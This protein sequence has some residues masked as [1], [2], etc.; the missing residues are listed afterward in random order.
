VC[1]WWCRRGPPC[2]EVVGRLI[3]WLIH[4]LVGDGQFRR[5]ETSGFPPPPPT[6]P[7]LQRPHLLAARS[8][9]CIEI[10]VVSSSS[11][12]TY[13]IS[14]DPT[15]LAHPHSS[16]VGWPCS[17][18]PCSTSLGGRLVGWLRG[19]W[20]VGCWSV[21]CG[22]GWCWGCLVARRWLGS[23]VDGRS[24]GW[25]VG[26]AQKDDDFELPPSHR[27]QNYSRAVS[28][29]HSPTHPQTHPPSH[30]PPRQ[31]LPHVPLLDHQLPVVDDEEGAGGPPGVGEE[32][33]L[34]E[35]VVVDQAD[36]VL[37]VFLGGRGWS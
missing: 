20:L 21:G 28:S 3:N 27:R 14:P 2:I 4:W 23:P 7:T 25:N 26:A 24:V 15:S 11:V 34:L 13:S 32:S 10:I 12:S 30:P 5:F 31:Q 16:S 22:R 36:L 37:F 1:R 35:G 33:Q 6:P 17:S 18:T 9:M 8:R 19:G 29:P